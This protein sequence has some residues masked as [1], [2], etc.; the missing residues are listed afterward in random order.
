MTNISINPISNIQSVIINE[1]SQQINSEHV[2]TEKSLNLSKDHI[3]IEVKKGVIPTLEGA[4]IGAVFGATS[5]IAVAQIIEKGKAFA[6]EGG[7]AMI[8]VVVVGLAVGSVIGG[9][10]A[11]ITHSKTKATIG[12]AISG[13]I[14][15]AGIVSIT[16]KPNEI[17]IAAGLGAIIGAASAFGGSLVSKT[18]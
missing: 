4:G 9:A 13:A 3:K 14:T 16:G 1:K 5:T 15:G 10:T 7:L 18:K 12:G 17:V 2:K 11:N 6:G 8:P